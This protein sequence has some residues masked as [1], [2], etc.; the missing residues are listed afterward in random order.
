MVIGWIAKHITNS[1]KHPCKTDIVFK[2][3]CESERR[4][5]EDC[6]EGELKN[7]SARVTELRDDT[8]AGLTKIEQMIIKNGR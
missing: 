3:V 5:I 2:E 7:L 6:V 1:K 8:K 4:R